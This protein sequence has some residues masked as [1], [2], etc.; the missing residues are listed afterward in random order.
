MNSESSLLG[1]GLEN[2]WHAIFSFAAREID[3]VEDPPL[4]RF[5]LRT[6][7]LFFAHVTV[8]FPFQIGSQPCFVGCSTRRYA[9]DNHSNKSFLWVKS[10]RVTL[11]LMS[12]SAI[13]AYS[14]EPLTYKRPSGAHF[15]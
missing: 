1:C 8:N 7:R 15:D 2:Q 3:S 14:F 12:T 5:S 13:S 11:N 10:I 9:Y 4:I 6:S